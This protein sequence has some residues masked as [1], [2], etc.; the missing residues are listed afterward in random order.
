MLTKY[1]YGASQTQQ[2]S[3]LK[4]FTN[5]TF[6]QISKVKQVNSFQSEE[7][8]HHISSRM[9]KIRQPAYSNIA[10]N[11]PPNHQYGDERSPH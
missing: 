1:K 7:T 5:N 11:S 2:T 6:H 8:S 3:R 4:L 10:I 9:Q